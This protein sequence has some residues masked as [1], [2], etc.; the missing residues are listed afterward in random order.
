MADKNDN[1]FDLQFKA[2]VLSW[3]NTNSVGG[4][5]SANVTEINSAAILAALLDLALPGEDQL[6]LLRYMEAGVPTNVADTAP[7]PVLLSSLAGPI[8]VTAG[9][10]NVQLSHLG[11]N[12]DS[13][14]IGDGTNLLAINTDGSL[15]I[16]NSNI[17]PL[18][19]YAISRDDSTTTTE[20]Y[21]FVDITGAWYIMKIDTTTG[22]YLYAKGTTNFMVE[23]GN[24]AT[25]VVYDEFNNLIW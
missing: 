10:L 25:T 21:G 17:S 16:N 8:N 13:T 2:K 24:R 12:Y 15:N 11:I 7:L 6:T 14:R 9:D 4:P 1:R 5:G 20:Y 23:W 3:L 19:K 18:D 22:I